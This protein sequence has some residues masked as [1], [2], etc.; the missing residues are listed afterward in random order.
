MGFYV[1]PVVV[2]NYFHNVPKPA[3]NVY[4]L[5][6]AGYVNQEQFYIQK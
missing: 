2:K 1:Q 4:T 6:S 5:R 3:I